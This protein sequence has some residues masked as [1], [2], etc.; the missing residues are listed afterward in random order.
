MTGKDR[1]KQGRVLEARPRSRVI[2]ENL[3]SSSGTEAAADA[4]LEPH[5]RHA[6]D[7]RRRHRERRADRRLERHARLPG[8][9]A[10]DARRDQFKEIKGQ[11]VK[12]RVCRRADCGQEIDR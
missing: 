10:A 9:Q 12:V 3:N 11:K 7:A 4:R 1:G 2:V 8:L 6:D 5:G